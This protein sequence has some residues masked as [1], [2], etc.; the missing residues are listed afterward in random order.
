MGQDADVEWAHESPQPRLSEAASAP[1]PAPTEVTE[2][3]QRRLE[4][5]VIP[6]RELERRAIRHA[7]EVTRG[8]VGRAARLL[9]IGRA[10]LYRRLAENG[11][12]H[13]T[14]R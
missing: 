5:E 4:S 14:Q 12:R 10:T 8:N 2:E 7:L 3:E 13:R 11:S 6:L 9:G 1:D